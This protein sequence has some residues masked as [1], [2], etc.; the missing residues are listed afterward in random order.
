M[1]FNELSKEQQVMVSMRKVLTSIIREITPPAGQ[2][3]PLT[4]QTF[5]DVRMCLALIAA[6]EQELANE[7]GIDNKSRPHYVDESKTTVPL[8]HIKKTSSRR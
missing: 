4:E 2:E 6:R 8:H 7:Q 5:N 3:Y 1:N